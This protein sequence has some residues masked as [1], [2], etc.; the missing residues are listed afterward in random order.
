MDSDHDVSAVAIEA[1]LSAR[2]CVPA[3]TPPNQTE[4]SYTTA[5]AASF[6]HS[7]LRIDQRVRWFRSVQ[8]S[9]AEC[10]RF[11]ALRISQKPEMADLDQ[12]GRQDVEEKPADKLDGV[13]LS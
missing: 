6:H 2:S 9:S 3:G 1:R 7:W 13:Q 11:A 4:S 5:R 10:E 8:K 12:A